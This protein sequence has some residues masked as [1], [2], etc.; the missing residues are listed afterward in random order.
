M[1]LLVMTKFSLERMLLKTMTTLWRVIRYVNLC[2]NPLACS[3]LP[4]IAS[5]TNCIKYLGPTLH[6]CHQYHYL[7]L[8][9]KYFFSFDFFLQYMQCPLYIMACIQ[10]TVISSTIWYFA[11]NWLKVL[12]ILIS[13]SKREIYLL[14]LCVDI[15]RI[16]G[17]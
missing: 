10:Y 8:S 17:Y 14:V 4:K 16:L 13:I 6:N 15:I 3:F 11:T 7:W 1:V 2:N 5:F 12:L 9:L